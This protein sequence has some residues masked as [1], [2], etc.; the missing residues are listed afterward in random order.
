M[1]SHMLDTQILGR[2][3]IPMV[4]GKSNCQ[5]CDKQ[6][7]TFHSVH[8]EE[9]NAV[10]QINPVTNIVSASHDHPTR[11]NH[12]L[13]SNMKEL[14]QQSVCKYLVNIRILMIKV[15]GDMIIFHFKVSSP[16]AME[17]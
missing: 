10:T 5:F 14:F 9:C 4:R 16:S 12:E 13:H 1:T 17:S 7:S 3:M 2:L 11:R 15:W 6:N 8:A